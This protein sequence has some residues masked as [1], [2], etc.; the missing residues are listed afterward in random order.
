MVDGQGVCIVMQHEVAEGN[1]K[2]FLSYS[3]FITYNTCF[4]DKHFNQCLAGV[5]LS[6]PVVTDS[7]CVDPCP[8]STQNPNWRHVIL[9][10]IV[11]G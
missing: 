9:Y 10:H 3:M 5:G 11:R 7:T 6:Q 2:C 4:F 1:G 8:I